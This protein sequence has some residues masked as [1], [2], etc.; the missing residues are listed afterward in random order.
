[1]SCINR[2]YRGKGPGLLTA[3]LSAQVCHAAEVRLLSG[4]ESGRTVCAFS[5]SRTR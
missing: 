1:M 5:Y 3:E 2:K 4:P